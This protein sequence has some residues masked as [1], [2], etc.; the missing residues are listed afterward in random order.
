MTM[1]TL[2]STPA[3][4][5]IVIAI[6]GLHVPQRDVWAFGSRV[7]GSTKAFSDLDLVILGEQP[8]P[9]ATMAELAQAFIESD[10][11][12]KVDIVDWAVTSIFSQN[13]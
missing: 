8:L 2:A 4:L 7:Q 11:P 3:E 12:Y 10:L 6:L 1:L 9:L 5:A 13:H